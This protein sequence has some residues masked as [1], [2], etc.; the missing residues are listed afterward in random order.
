LFGK[1]G[2]VGWELQRALQPLGEVIALGRE[3]AAEDLCGELT[4]P[5]GIGRTIAA[6]RPDAVV[7]AAAYTAVD[8]AESETALA[9]TV[10]ARAPKAMAE[11]A[12]KIGAWL[13]HYSTDYVFPGTGTRPWTEADPTG[14]LSAYGRSKL[15]G[16]QAI[17]EMSGRY[18]VLRTSW[19]YAARGSNFATT[20]LRLARERDTLDVVDDQI[21][22]PT[23]AEL[24]ADVTALILRHL[25]FCSGGTQEPLSG[26]YHLAADGHT[27][28]HG[29]ARRVLQ[30]AEA[31]GYKLRVG[32][33][34]IGAIPSSAYPTPAPRPL[35][36]RL[37]TEKIRQAFDLHLPRWETGVV[38]MLRE[39]VSC[40]L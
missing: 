16:E 25:L 37:N 12:R 33:D 36:S 17:A 20:M 13:V 15:E 39:V 3:R 2:Q 28:W 14:P 27:S 34:A 19:V 10:N 7:N 31:A 35:N 26:V 29:Y 32:S 22:A 6:V 30:A 9:W 24:I 1:N 8:R 4:D 21:G 38:R 11:A 23:G 18:V 5:A 40:R